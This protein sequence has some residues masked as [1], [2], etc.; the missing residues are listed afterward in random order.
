M[1]QFLPNQFWTKALATF[2][3]EKRRNAGLKRQ[4]NA[5]LKVLSTMRLCHRLLGHSAT[6]LRIDLCSPAD[7]S[8]IIKIKKRKMMGFS[9]YLSLVP[10]ICHEIKVPKRQLSAFFFDCPSNMYILGDIWKKHAEIF[11]LHLFIV[12]KCFGCLNMNRVPGGHQLDNTSENVT[13][14]NWFTV[15]GQHRLLCEC[16][17]TVR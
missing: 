17:G 13:S 15:E 11:L 12:L 5:L 2:W 10:A 6:K 1:P 8:F 14:T 3:T 16:K 4:E 9:P 7:F